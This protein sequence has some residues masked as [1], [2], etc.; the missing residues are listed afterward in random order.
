MS[1]LPQTRLKLNY[2]AIDVQAIC[3]RREGKHGQQN[4]WENMGEAER[5]KTYSGHLKRSALFEE[6]RQMRA[7]RNGPTVKSFPPFR[8]TSSLCSENK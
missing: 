3:L 4:A 8:D 5:A 1:F 2:I 6:T 7:K